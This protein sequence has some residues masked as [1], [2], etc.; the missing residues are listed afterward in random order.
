MRQRFG[1]R[2]EGNSNGSSRS[3]GGNRSVIAAG[4][5]RCLSFLCWLSG[6][7]FLSVDCGLRIA[8]CGGGMYVC[9]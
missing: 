4:A 9:R 8:D 7:R 1:A 3:R 5:R 2:C 6:G